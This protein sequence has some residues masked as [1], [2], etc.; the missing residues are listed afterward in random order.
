MKKERKLNKFFQTVT[1]YKQRTV[2]KQWLSQCQTKVDTISGATHQET[3]LLVKVQNKLIETVH[4]R[5]EN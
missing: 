4:N 1:S 3:T 2:L 5:I